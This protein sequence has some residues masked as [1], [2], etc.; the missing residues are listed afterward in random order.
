M[1]C[2]ANNTEAPSRDG[3]TCSSDEV[4]VIVKERRGRV[5]QSGMWVNCA[6]R[7]NP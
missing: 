1:K 2:E 4:T 5:I 3:A 7:R 6:S